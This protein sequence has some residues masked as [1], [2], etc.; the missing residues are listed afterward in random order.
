MLLLLAKPGTLVAGQGS[1]QLLHLPVTAHTLSF[2]YH[3]HLSSA[4]TGGSVGLFS[5]SCSVGLST[6]PGQIDVYT[7]LL[8]SIMLRPCCS[9]SHGSLLKK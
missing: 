2:V 3:H 5:G 9:S 1:V 7:L 4:G 6:C 8:S